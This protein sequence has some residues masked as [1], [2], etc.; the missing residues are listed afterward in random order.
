[1]RNLILLI[2]LINYVYGDFLCSSECNIA[3]NDKL[4]TNATEKAFHHETAWFTFAENSNNNKTVSSYHVETNMKGQQNLEGDTIKSTNIRL[5]QSYQASY[6]NHQVR[7]KE[8]YNA[9][10]SSSRTPRKKG[11]ISGLKKRTPSFSFKVNPSHRKNEFITANMHASDNISLFGRGD[12]SHQEEEESSLLVSPSM[13][14]QDL[15]CSG[16]TTKKRRQ[17]RHLI[18]PR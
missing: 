3:S 14:G 8:Y 13:S 17:C 18:H 7:T 2:L 10:P 16:I 9:A 1:M 5:I 15:L 4:V 6:K 11:A 12:T